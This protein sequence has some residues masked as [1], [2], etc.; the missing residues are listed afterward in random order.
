MW[1]FEYFSTETIAIDLSQLTGKGR[2]AS[3]IRD[4]EPQKIKT[5]VPWSIKNSL[6]SLQYECTHWCSG[7]FINSLY[8]LTVRKCA[9]DLSNKGLGWASALFSVNDNVLTERRFIKEVHDIINCSDLQLISV[10]SSI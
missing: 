1:Y 2:K 8:I 7:F 3:V 9:E 4:R 6:V 5:H 10:S